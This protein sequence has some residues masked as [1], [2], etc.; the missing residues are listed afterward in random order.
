[1][2]TYLKAELEVNIC[3]MLA[4]IRIHDDTTDFCTQKVSVLLEKLP[5]SLSC[6]ETCHGFVSRSLCKASVTRGNFFCNLCRNAIA[7]QV[8]D[9]LPSVTYYSYAMQRG[10]LALTT[11]ASSR[12]PFYF[13]QRLQAFS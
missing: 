12:T 4:S 11:V 9:Q 13:L 3:T 2:I 8:A 6:Y 5:D 10:F 7:I 1:M